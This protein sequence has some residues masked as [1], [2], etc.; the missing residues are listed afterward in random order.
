MQRIIHIRRE[1]R[2]PEPSQR[3]H[4]RRC[5]ESTRCKARVRI[6]KIRLDTLVGN[7]IAHA[8]ECSADVGCDPVLVGFRG[9]AVDE[10]AG[11]SAEGCD[12]EEGDAEFGAADVAVLAFEATVDS[13]VERGADL[14]AEP[15]A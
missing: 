5:S 4:K 3:P 7:D 1:E 13:V 9:P 12:A 2:K 15:E 11:G 10:E 8:E 6:Y 14:R